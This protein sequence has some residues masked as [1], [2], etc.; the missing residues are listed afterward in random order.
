MLRVEG[1][2]AVRTE[3]KRAYAALERLLADARTEGRLRADAS[4]IDLR[5]LFAA[6]APSTN[7]NF[8]RGGA[9]PS[10]VRVAR[11]FVVAVSA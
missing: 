8:T 10:G 3:S 2:P 5:L 11:V 4:I 6:K 7:G 1:R 9:R